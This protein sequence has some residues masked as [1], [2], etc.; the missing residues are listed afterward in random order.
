MALLFYL[1]GEKMLTYMLVGFICYFI[2]LVT[3]LI[4]VKPEP[5]GNLRIDQSD[6]RDE[7]Y[8]FLEIEKGKLDTIRNK[9]TIFLKVLNENYIPRK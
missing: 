4:I 9:K 7:P 3:F 1:K 2:G 5:V 6:P 8:L